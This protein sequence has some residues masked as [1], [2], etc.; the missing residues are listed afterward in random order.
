MIKISII[1]PVYNASRYLDNCLK[2]LQ[3]ILDDERFEIIFVDDGSTDD[4]S[5][6]LQAYSKKFLNLKL[7]EQSNSGP[8]KAREN[9]FLNSSG[10]YISFMDSDDTVDED[11][12]L[13][14]Y[15][16]V[17][18]NSSIDLIVTNYYEIYKNKKVLMNSDLTSHPIDYNHFY[19][20]LLSITTRPI[21]AVNVWGKLYKKTA[22]LNDYFKSEF[23]LA[24]DLLFNE[25]ILKSKDINIYYIGDIFYFYL[26]R[27]NSLIRT[28]NNQFET[29]DAEILFLKRNFNINP[30]SSV[31]LLNKIYLDYIRA[32]IYLYSIN[33][34][35]LKSIEI[36]IHDCATQ[37]VKINWKLKAAFSFF[38]AFNCASLGFLCF[39]VRKILIKKNKKTKF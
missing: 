25:K 37:D 26:I 36:K 24:E 35:K 31:K 23:K 28:K 12:Y 39:I 15:E 38:K 17:S 29:L 6:K 10:N 32:Y 19:E 13:R 22:I 5:C 9:G 7:V 8:A 34:K 18:M 11:Y 27:N 20:N 21:N 1:V 16:I 3:K 4:T 2:S 33:K 30:E 14:L